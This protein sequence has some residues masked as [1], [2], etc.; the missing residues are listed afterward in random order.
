M[1][2]PLE[3]AEREASKSR[4]LPLPVKLAEAAMN[5]PLEAAEREASKSRRLP[6]PV[7]LAAAERK[8]PSRTRRLRTRTTAAQ[9][10][11]ALGRFQ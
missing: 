5:H 2:H 7:K 6:L 11:F 3:A 10:S 9:C 8:R 4:R 1:N